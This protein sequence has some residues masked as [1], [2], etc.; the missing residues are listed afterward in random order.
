ML[1][2]AC[3]KEIY[4]DNVDFDSCATLVVEQN[5]E[6]NAMSTR[7]SDDTQEVDVVQHMCMNEPEVVKGQAD[8]GE[9]NEIIIEE[10]DNVDYNGLYEQDI[11]HEDEDVEED[12]NNDEPNNP[13]PNEWNRRDKAT[14]DV[15]DTHH[16]CWEYGS[17]FIHINQGRC[18]PPVRR[19]ATEEEK[20]R[21]GLDIL[22]DGYWS[23][24]DGLTLISDHLKKL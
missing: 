4:E 7:M 16:S 15:A 20:G 13:A 3:P 18:R 11:L 24:L 17:S 2:Q 6:I 19:N 10:L 1:V 21:K 23:K 14:M 9:V 12:D 5:S 22:S 8:T